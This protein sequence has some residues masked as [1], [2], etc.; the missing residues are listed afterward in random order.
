MA[1]AWEIAT[2]L[3][4]KPI[5]TLRYSRALFAQPIKESMLR[6]LSF[7]LALEGLSVAALTASPIKSPG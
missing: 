7:G 2:K 3:A 4:S 1:R 6:E 5:T